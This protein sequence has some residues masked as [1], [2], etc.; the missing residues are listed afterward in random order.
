MIFAA[1]KEKIMTIEGVVK[2]GAIILKD[3]V[4]VPE[5][6]RVQVVIPD[7]ALK[8]TNLEQSDSTLTLAV[9]LKYAGC[10]KDLPPDF[11]EQHDHYIHGLPRR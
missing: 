7:Q 2:N 5:G 8:S 11:A 1:T 9:L 10:M 4:E 6:T 3:G